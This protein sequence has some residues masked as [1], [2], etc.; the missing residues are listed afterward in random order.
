VPAR[1]FDVHR[2]FSFFLSPL[3]SSTAGGQ[4]LGSR[5]STTRVEALVCAGASGGARC[6]RLFFLS[7]SSL[8]VSVAG[9]RSE[10]SNR[11]SVACACLN[12]NPGRLRA[13]RDAIGCCSPSLPFFFFFFPPLPPKRAISEGKREIGRSQPQRRVSPVDRCVRM[14]GG[15]FSFFFFL[16]FLPLPVLVSATMI[17]VAASEVASRTTVSPCGFRGALDPLFFFFIF[18]RS[19]AETG[20]HRPTRATASASLI[21]GSKA[22]NDPLFLF[23]IFFSPGSRGQNGARA[24]TR[25]IGHRSGWLKSGYPMA[26]DEVASLSFFSGR[27]RDESTV[28][29]PNL[30]A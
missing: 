27:I 1:L 21:T 11:P 10:R 23:F 8:H 7:P 20:L 2:N 5:G 9:K 18:A 14:A 30:P 22:K 3:L 6:V 28:S 12:R 15:F 16:S 29:L 25:S 26:G 13:T 4:P 17:R 24:V 19:A